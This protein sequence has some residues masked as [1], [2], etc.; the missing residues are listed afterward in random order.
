MFKKHKQGAELSENVKN[1]IFN[2]N[3]KNISLTALELCKKNHN[4]VPI[5]L[6]KKIHEKV[7]SIKQCYE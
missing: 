5:D 3:L 6:E 1:H 7:G 4:H 2:Y